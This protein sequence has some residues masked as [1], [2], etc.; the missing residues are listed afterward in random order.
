MLAAALLAGADAV[1]LGGGDFNAR[2]KSE[3]FSGDGLRRAVRL[4]RERGVELCFTAN[5]LVFEHELADFERALREAIAAGVEN[6]IVQDLAA[7]HLLRRI[8]DS[9][10]RLHASTQMAVHNADGLRVLEGL[11]FTRA[12]LARELLEEEIGSLTQG[13]TLETET[14][15]HGALCMSVS[16]LCYMSALIGGRSANRGLCA[17]AC[18][19]PYSVGGEQGGEESYP[20]SLKDNCLIAQVGRLHALGVDALKIEGRLRRP[21]YVEV[22][23]REY[24]KALRGDAPDMDALEGVFSRSGF[25]EGWY[26]GGYGQAAFGIRTA[27]DAERTLALRQEGTQNRDFSLAALPP[28]I[29]LRLRFVAKRAAQAQLFAEDALGRRVHVQGPVPE[30]AQTVGL[31]RES[32]LR[33]LTKLGGSAW[34]LQDEGDV[35]TEIEEG[36]F[37]KASELN[38]LR[39]AALEARTD[40]PAGAD[41]NALPQ[42]PTAADTTALPQSPTTAGTNASKNPHKCTSVEA[43]RSATDAPAA[44]YVR[45]ASAGQL[46]P[47]LTRSADRI[48]LNAFDD[49][50]LDNARPDGNPR[51]GGT[52]GGKRCA[53]LP[54]LLYG[55]SARAALHERLVLL[56]KAGVRHYYIAGLYGFAAV[57]RAWKEAVQAGVRGA[58]GDAGGGG[59]A[60]RPNLIGG[61]ELNIANSAALAEY[62]ALGLAECVL[63]PE[64]TA[65]SLRRIARAETVGVYAYGRPPL[66][67]F[68]ACPLAA[69]GGCRTQEKYGGETGSQTTFPCA[70]TDRTGRRFPLIC[71]RHKGSAFATWPACGRTHNASAP[72]SD[73]TPADGEARLL[74]AVPV[75]LFDKMESFTGASFLLLDFTVEEATECAATLSACHARKAPDEAFTR[76]L[77]FRKVL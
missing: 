39:R 43:H 29:S 38:A 65:H 52:L 26:A 73:P 57:E 48:I 59:S 23:V 60:D 6:F 53:A 62:S 67:H 14:F 4:C 44:L 16:G 77:Y 3:G 66:M 2:R 24:R 55:D 27:E 41:T 76:G 63:S 19:L 50:L 34:Y 7:L 56:A 69:R 74:N 68:R 47:A 61:F 31:T 17:Q 37:L 40:T 21:E 58:G 10:I 45:L 25:T 72:S 42:P 28:C 30:A 46:T 18:R 9:P 15:V 13:T 33:S 70:L 54:T 20:L 12:V 71:A 5:T 35:E 8:A 51:S 36:L 1:Y 22:A 64:V 11:G 75:W 32:A 49:A